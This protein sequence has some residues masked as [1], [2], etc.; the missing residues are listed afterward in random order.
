MRNSTTYFIM[1]TLWLLV[2]TPARADDPVLDDG[3]LF[4]RRAAAISE[5]HALD[6]EKQVRDRRQDVQGAGATPPRPVFAAAPERK[7]M[8]V[9]VYEIGGSGNA[10]LATFQ[11]ADGTL[12]EFHPGQTVPGFGTIR[13]IKPTAVEDGNGHFHAV[14]DGDE[15][16][17]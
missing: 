15:G 16:T 2:L 6:L 10:L 1:A 17:P 9:R 3:S 5:L 11:L 7:S 12:K 14:S 4:K 13:S 8:P